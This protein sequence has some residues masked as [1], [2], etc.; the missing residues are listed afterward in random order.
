MASGYSDF[1]LTVRFFAKEEDEARRE[2]QRLSEIAQK[3]GVSSDDEESAMSPSLST[4]K[5]SDWDW[6]FWSEEPKGLR[7]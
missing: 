6:G 3:H 1:S 2:F 4:D 5:G 7:A